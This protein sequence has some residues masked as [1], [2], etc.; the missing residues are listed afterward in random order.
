[1]ANT[2]IPTGTAALAAAARLLRLAGSEATEA[3]EILWTASIGG[4][5]RLA[6]ASST[7]VRTIRDLHRQVVAAVA[8]AEGDSD[9]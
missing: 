7:A 8:A 3:R 5:Q 4:D 2:T 1:M 9:A 6:I